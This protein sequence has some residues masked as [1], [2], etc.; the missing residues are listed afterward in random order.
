MNKEFKNIEEYLEYVGQGR[1]NAFGRRYRQQFRDTQ[2]TAELAMLAAPS[3]VEYED[4]RRA[5]AAMTDDERQRP[6][7]LNDVQIQEIA[8]RGQADAGNV[9]IFVNGFVLA[10]RGQL[11]R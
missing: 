2:G 4:F 7:E 5:V 8:Q 1:K 6:E 9:S 3:E 11:K 10:C